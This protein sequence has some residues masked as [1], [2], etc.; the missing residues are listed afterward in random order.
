MHELLGHLVPIQ[1]IQVVHAPTDPLPMRRKSQGATDIGVLAQ[2]TG[3]RH[4]PITRQATQGGAACLC[5]H[6]GDCMTVHSC[7]QGQDPPRIASA[8]EAVATLPILIEHMIGQSRRCIDPQT[9]DSAQSRRLQ[10]GRSG[11]GVR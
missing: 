1:Q 8:C 7:R 5:G 10:M 4:Q 3:Q 6:C 11:D 2:G 9:R